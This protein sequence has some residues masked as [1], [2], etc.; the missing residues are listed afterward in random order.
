MRPE[1]AFGSFPRGRSDQRAIIRNHG[2]PYFVYNR[3]GA[4]RSM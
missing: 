3:N 2:T 4:T 1:M